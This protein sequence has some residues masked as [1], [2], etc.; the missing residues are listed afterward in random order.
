LLGWPARHCCEWEHFNLD[1]EKASLVSAGVVVKF[2][3]F[4]A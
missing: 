2:S 3:V 1:P 4:V